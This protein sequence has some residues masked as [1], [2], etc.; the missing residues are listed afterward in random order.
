[1]ARGEEQNAEKCAGHQELR[2]QILRLHRPED[3]ASRLL[4]ASIATV[5][6]LTKEKGGLVSSDLET[7]QWQWEHRKGFRDYPSW[8]SDRLEAAFQ[9]GD[10]RVRL[11]SGKREETPMEV[12][13]DDMIQYDLKTGNI[14]RIRRVGKMSWPDRLQR[15]LKA[16]SRMLEPSG[17]EH[18]TNLA[19]LERRRREIAIAVG[20]GRTAELFASG[21]MCAAV[22]RSQLFFATSMLAVLAN[23][24]W[25]G[26][27]SDSH[28][29]D[30]FREVGTSGQMVDH[31]FCVL[32]SLELMVRFFAYRR[33][34]DCLCDAWFVLD[35]SL[36]GLGVFETWL[37]PLTLAIAGAQP[38]STFYS[39]FSILRLVRIV[40]LTRLM[41][42]FRLLRVLPEVMILLKGIAA[43]ARSLFFTVLLLSVLLF[44]FAVILR[45]QS[46]ENDSLKAM[47]SS[48]PSSMWILLLDGI[49]MDGPA[50][51][52]SAIGEE[53]SAMSYVFLLFIFLSH[54]TVLNMLIGI[55]CDVVKDIAAAE[56]DR[57]A[58]H[59]LQTNV[60]ELLQSHDRDSD[61]HIQKAEF[62]LLMQNPEMCF[63]LT[64]FG[65]NVSDLMS[66]KDVLFEDIQ[67]VEDD[68]DSDADMEGTPFCPAKLS[69]VDFLEVVLRLR[70]GN[71]AMVT[72]VV[73]VREYFQERWRLYE[74]TVERQ[75]TELENFSDPK[76]WPPPGMAE[77]AESKELPVDVVSCLEDLCCRQRL[78]AEQQAAWQEQAEARQRHLASEVQRL[79]EQLCQL[80]RG[81]AT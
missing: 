24:V 27:E 71:A 30:S 64:R 73:Q 39:E 58:V 81:P 49:L 52:L 69:F 53:S 32:F 56:K 1:M 51:R 15:H 36:V 67:A 21:G 54:Y 17:L 70:G 3:S 68:S 16:F 12:F 13:F 31:I 19:S 48:V 8:A 79:N 4:G 60:L 45:T 9:S 66:L 44:I 50:G 10:F 29:Y 61:R 59:Y 55:L 41:R 5:P 35:A 65:V 40:R 43:A 6:R 18:T 42:M 74:D 25:I 72:D 23:S 62:E 2:G 57:L 11:R 38:D 47:F 46:S 28:Q 33:T 34:R 37:I 63:V 76:L 14:R 78:L 22:A 80:Q 77:E 20:R 26:V 75:M 7:S